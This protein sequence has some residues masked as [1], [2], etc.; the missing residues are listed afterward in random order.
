MQ[1]RWLAPTNFFFEIGGEAFRGA[2]FPAG[3]AVNRGIGTHALFAHVGD[4]LNESSNFRTGLSWLRTS[5]TARET[6]SEF[7]TDTFT[8]DSNTFIYDLVY[9][10]APNGNRADQYVKLQGEYFLRQEKGTFNTLPYSDRQTGWYVQAVYQFMPKWRVGL[11]HDRLAS[12]LPNAA[13]AGTILDPNG[14]NPH[15]SS[16]MIDYSTSEFGRFR[17]Q[18]NRDQS[19]PETDNQAILQYTVSFGAHGAH[20]Y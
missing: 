11:R 3:G 16:A 13:L 1:V 15:R 5:A 6:T 20:P 7:G 4:D 19:G 17:L 14:A 18:Y 10:W 12:D 2:N 9:N 8:G